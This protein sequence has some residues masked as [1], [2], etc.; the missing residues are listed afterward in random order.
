MCALVWKKINNG[1][2]GIDF[3]EFISCR[4]F[5]KASVLQ[6]SSVELELLKEILKICS[7]K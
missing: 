5:Q 3:F 6:S 2:N 4:N 1:N 7:Q